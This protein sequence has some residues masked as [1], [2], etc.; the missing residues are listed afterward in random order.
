M[1]Q[2]RDISE[3]VKDEIPFIEWNGYRYDL[4][5]YSF[6]EGYSVDS[7]VNAVKRCTTS[8]TGLVNN[9]ALLKTISR[10]RLCASNDGSTGIDTIPSGMILVI[11]EIQLRYNSTCVYYVRVE[12]ADGKYKGWVSLSSSHYELYIRGERVVNE[13]KDENKL[14]QTWT[15]PAYITEDMIFDKNGVIYNF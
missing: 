1:S 8:G 10:M 14:Y 7:K 5:T 12:T 9:K 2:G 11:K 15:H 13:W 3:P 6:K 4:H